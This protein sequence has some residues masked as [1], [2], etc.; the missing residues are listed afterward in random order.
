[1]ASSFPSRCGRGGDEGPPGPD[2][3]VLR[4]RS[5]AAEGDGRDG[6]GGV[7]DLGCLSVVDAAILAKQPP[8]KMICLGNSRI[9]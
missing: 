5:S 4:L 7:G 3:A 2:A 1:M 6:D 8:Y 9:T